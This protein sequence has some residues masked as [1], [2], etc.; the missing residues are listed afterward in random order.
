MKRYSPSEIEPKW[1]QIWADTQLYRAEDGDQSRPKYYMLTEFP[2]PS[3]AGMHSGNGREYVLGDVISRYKRM[4]GHNVLYPM[5]WDAFGLPAENFAIKNKIHPAEAVSQNIANFKQQMTSL[6]LGFDWSREIN[7]TDPDYYKWTQWLF[8]Q[9]L[10]AGLAYQ[11][12]IPINWC[13]KE[14]T[15]LANEEVVNGLHERCGTPVE[16]KVLKQWMLKITAYADRLIEGLKTVDFPPRIAD[17]QINWIGRS[18]GAEIDFT[19][20][21]EKITVYTTRPDT[22][23]GATFLVLAPEHPA[24]AKITTADQRATVEQYVKDA[25]HQTELERQE[26]ERPKT[27]AFTGTY[28][29]NPITHEQMPVWI[30]DYVLMGYGTAAIMAVPAHDERDWAFAKVNKIDIRTVINPVMVRDD[31]KDFKE[32]VKKRKIVATVENAKGEIL[33]I[34]WGPDMGGRLTVGGTIEGDETPE[35]TAL[36]EVAE[37]TGYHD[38]EVVEVGQETLNYKYYAHSKKRACEADVNFVHIRLHSDKRGKQRL[39]DDEKGYFKVEWVSR[40]QAEREITEPLHRYGLNKFILGKPFTG[41]G[42]LINSG[43]FDGLSGIEAKRSV[44]KWLFDQGI[45]RG[46]TKYRLRDWIFSRQHYWGEPIPVVHCPKDGVVPV[47]DDQLP[48]TLPEV[49][50]YEPTDTGESP[51]AAISDWVNTTCP[52]CGGPAKR[53]TDTMPNWAGSSWYWLRYTDPH[54]SK[55]FA[56][57]TKLEYWTPVDL[58]LGGMEHTTLHLLYSRFWNQFLYDQKLVPTPEPYAARRGQ[59]IVLAADGRKMSKSLGNVINPTDIIDRYGADAFRLYILFMAPYDETTPWSD[60]R[61]GGVS[62]FAY[63]VWSLAQDLIANRVPS[64]GASEINTGELT[65]TVDRTTHKTLKKIHD[66]LEGMRFNTMVSTL[67]EYVNFLNEPRTRAA[68]TDPANADLAQRTVRALVLM[69]A[70]AAPHITEELW[71]ELGEEGS[72]HIAPWPTYD[73]ALIKDDVV[74]VIVQINGKMRGQLSVPVDLTEA[75]LINLATA[76]PHVAPYL[77]GQTIA[78]TVVVPRKLVNFV[79]R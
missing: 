39:E 70:P 13:P 47:P 11:A 22:L 5:G 45:G 60:E 78:R 3:A 19:V 76:E 64:T 27:G 57:P 30:A 62:R 12:E 44:T 20:G 4:N 61:L 32:F 37:E 21:G 55:A 36:R 67:M 79:V 49:E 68:L 34:N 1:Q 73:P 51:L 9:F 7:T 40:E 35:A 50:H 74:T 6:G 28:A 23:A 56:D 24:V 69:L 2:Y 65:V 29:E 18:E 71:H 14:K 48:V 52:Q 17:Q 59:G 46:A 63:R 31:A 38:L 54:N 42:P 15:G 41:E 75:D 66:D 8:L 25:Q 10:K 43:Q 26:E 58:Y 77:D 53:E 33:T 72:V 16:K